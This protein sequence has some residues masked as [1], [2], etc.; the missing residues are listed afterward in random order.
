MEENR[1]VTSGRTKG[2][3]DWSF[4]D[5]TLRLDGGDFIGESVMP[6]A[7]LREQIDW[8]EITGHCVDL[9]SYAFADCTA[10]SFVKMNGIEEISEGAFRGCTSL[11][12]F[13]LPEFLEWLYED[14][15]RG[16]TGLK[17][18]ILPEYLWQLG[19]GAFAECT[20]LTTVV[21]GEGLLGDDPPPVCMYEGRYDKDTHT[22]H[23]ADVFIGCWNL[24]TILLPPGYDDVTVDMEGVTV[25]SV[26]EAHWPLSYDDT[27]AINAGDIRTTFW[28]ANYRDGE[29]PANFRI[30][31]G[32][33]KIAKNAFCYCNHLTSVTIPASVKT[34]D[35][36]A[37]S[38]CSNLTTVVLEEGLEEIGW[39]AFAYCTNLTD[40]HL[41]S[42]LRIIDGC[43]FTGCSALREIFIP[44]GVEKIG[45]SAFEDCTQLEK[46][47]I[48]ETFQEAYRTIEKEAFAGCIRLTEVEIP[49]GMPWVGAGAFRDCT[50][51]RTVYISRGIMSV[52]KTA[53]EGC[54]NLEKII[55]TE[56]SHSIFY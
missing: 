31:D 56:V 30:P 47:T 32:F 46:L 50:G 8:V 7:H 10:L 39:S 49:E 36:N 26:P 55:E 52:H 45:E 11:T 9:D 35:D 22:L 21:V 29:D 3:M 24:K 25:F 54:T 5:G 14:A 4:D 53:F 40:I 28:K 51:L 20:N 17:S 34:I 48:E 16:C 13:Y 43:A 2:G 15:F 33:T 1:I 42:S 12:N 27:D 23:I 37:F 41:P 44:K 6:W 19:P 38:D 18:V